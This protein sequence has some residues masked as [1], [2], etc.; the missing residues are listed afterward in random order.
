LVDSN[1]DWGQ[2]LKNLKRYLDDRHVLEPCVSYYGC[3]PVAYYGIRPRE[4]PPIPQIEDALGLDCVAAISATHLATQPVKF[5]R[6]DNLEPEAR[7][8]YSIYLYGLR[9]SAR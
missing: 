2:D 4:L 8:G 5:A 6:L 3:A 7:I 1:L 9:K